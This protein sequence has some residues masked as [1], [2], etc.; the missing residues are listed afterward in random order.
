VPPISIANGFLVTLMSR[1][2]FKKTIVNFII[3][4]EAQLSEVNSYFKN[5]IYRS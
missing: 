5:K 3:G 4:Q 2:R 1:K